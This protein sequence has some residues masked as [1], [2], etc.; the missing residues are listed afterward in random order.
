MVMEL[1]IS[2]LVFLFIIPAILAAVCRDLLRS[3]IALLFCSLG[4]TLLL[5]NLNAPL[6][7]VFELSVGAG[8]ISVLFINAISLT[9]PLSAEENIT[10][11]KDH[12]RRFLGLPFIIIIIAALLWFNQQQ[13]FGKLIFQKT[14]E[15]ATIGQILWGFRGLDLI[16][17]IVILLVGVYGIVVLFKRGRSND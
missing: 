17:Q 9:R 12:Y 5:F 10:R 2:I 15:N 8:L 6:A 11:R 13:I 4:L 14:A 1:H 16:G 3:V 7:G